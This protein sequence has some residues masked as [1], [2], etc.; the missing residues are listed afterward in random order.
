[1]HAEARTVESQ[2]SEWRE[3]IGADET[4]VD[5]DGNFALVGRSKAEMLAQRGQN[6]AQLRRGQEVW[7][8]TAKVHLGHFAW[9][10]ERRH[11]LDLA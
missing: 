8:A 7:R 9:S 5:L 1:M 11:H 6:L 10:E 2:A 4:R 3:I